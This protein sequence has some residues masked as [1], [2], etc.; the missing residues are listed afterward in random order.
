MKKYQKQGLYCLKALLPAHAMSI[1]VR[2]K[3]CNN[4]KRVGCSKEEISKLLEE[5]DYFHFPSIFNGAESGIDNLGIKFKE[6]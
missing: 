1:F 3:P 2:F 5:C 4:C 6:V